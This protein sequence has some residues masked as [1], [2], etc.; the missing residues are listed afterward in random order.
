MFDFGK[1][2]PSVILREGYRVE[3]LDKRITPVYISGADY[4][5]KGTEMFAY[6]G[7][8]DRGREKYPVI[9]LIHGGNGRAYERWTTEWVDRGFIAL[10]IDNNGRHQTENGIEDNPLGG[11]KAWTPWRE[12][13]S[14]T[15]NTWAYVSVKTLLMAEGLLASL[16]LA[17]MTRV[18]S[19]GISWGGYLSYLYL[20]HTK[21]VRLG[22]VSYTT[23]YMEDIPEWQ[24]GGLTRAYA[25]EEIYNL[26][27]NKF[28]AK[29]FIPK[30]KIPTVLARG[31]EDRCFPPRTINKTLEL[32][33]DGVVTM[34]NIKKY[35]HGQINGSSMVDVNG[36][37]CDD[38]YGDTEAPDSY[39]Y[40]VIYTLESGPD[41]LDKEWRELNISRE[42]Y[43]EGYRP[44]CVCWYYN[45]ISPRGYLVSSRIYGEAAE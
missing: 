22:C 39:N 23:A 31:M 34:A 12:D 5:G 21:L 7:I 15:E 16:P 13:L 30:I 35:V 3:G 20:A 11:P 14:D 9:L 36:R 40:S 17:D 45:K 25:G 42:Q 18:Y 10:A 2:T 44:E 19:H 37:I 6:L 33:A 24:K 8:P 27:V 4:K 38:A 43:E 32:F 28:D 41:S 26:W 29:N 1:I